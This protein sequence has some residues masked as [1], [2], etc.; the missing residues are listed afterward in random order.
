MTLTAS[1]LPPTGMGLVLNAGPIVGGGFLSIDRPNGRYAAV[2]QISLFG[3]SIEG[4]ALIDT[5]LPGGESGFSFLVLVFADFEAIGG[6]QLSFGF[7]LTGVG[8]VFGIFRSVNTDG[9]RSAVLS[10]NLDHLLFPTDP[11][12][13]A[14]AII[15]DLRAVFRQLVTNMSLVQSCEW[16]G[17][18]QSSLRLNW[19]SCSTFLRSLWRYW[20]ALEFICQ[21]SRPRSWK[22]TSISPAASIPDTARWN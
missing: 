12:K 14:P 22:S 2:V 6:I 4:F 3:L 7:V 8:G 18:L 20:E 5:K 1:Y 11:I 17:E 10:N 15:S 13:N 21:S 19:V 9:L 16:A